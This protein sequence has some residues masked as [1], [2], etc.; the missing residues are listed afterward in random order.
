MSSHVEI[1]ADE[2]PVSQA[3]NEAKNGLA[4]AG[5]VLGSV[6]AASC[7]I[8]P[9]VLFSLGISGAWIG[10]L[11]AL[12]PYQPIFIVMTLGFLGAGFWMVYRKPKAACAEGSAC[13]RPLPNRIV[14]TALWGAALLVAAALAFP[15]AAPLF[16]DY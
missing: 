4:A 14:K 7:C 15:Y 9:L 2:R 3:K 6:A 11:T 13:S 8:A 12:K 5:G 1:A 16:L 10:A